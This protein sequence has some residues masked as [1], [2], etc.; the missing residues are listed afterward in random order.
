M[1]RK[2]L[3]GGY[4]SLAATLCTTN[5]A[6]TISNG[7]ASCFMHGPTFMGNPLACS[8]ANVSIDLLLQNNWQAQ[9]KQIESWFNQAIK[10]LGEN[11]RVKN[12]RV[13][14]SIAVVE[15][16][17]SVNVATIQQ[18]FVEQGVWIRPFGKLI[19]M[20]PPLIIT[21]EQIETLINAIASALPHD[22]FFND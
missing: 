9:V 3:T 11:K 14:G 16:H 10:P 8:V 19:Y 22:K 2:T 6:E 5:I 12:V 17:Q 15:T 18:H 4:L 13:L 21:Q 7:E 20:M 1:F